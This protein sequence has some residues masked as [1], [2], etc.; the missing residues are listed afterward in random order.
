ME[1]LRKRLST[2]G[3]AR[4]KQGCS[5][6]L[7]PGS[8]MHAPRGILSSLLAAS[9]EK[10]LAP[11][12]ALWPLQRSPALEMTGR[13][14]NSSVFNVLGEVNTSKVKCCSHV[15]PCQLMRD[16]E[17]PLLLLQVTQLLHGIADLYVVP[18]VLTQIPKKCLKG[19]H[20]D[21][22]EEKIRP[23]S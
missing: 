19:S 21:T 5:C 22:G 4:L 6:A 7:L 13:P 10:G 8:C 9:C 23:G 12:A 17:H 11:C 20:K 3:A 14:F 16:E 15:G 1:F 2:A 18:G